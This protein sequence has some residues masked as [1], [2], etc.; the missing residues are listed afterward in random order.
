MPPPN[1]E[2]HPVT[3]SPSPS[4]SM[5][6]E[7]ENAMAPSLDPDQS[8]HQSMHTLHTSS[9]LLPTST[10][11]MLATGG[12][13][14][15]FLS[16]IVPSDH[17][18]NEAAGD[19]ANVNSRPSSTFVG[20]GPQLYQPDSVFTNVENGVDKKGWALGPTDPTIELTSLLADL[21]QYDTK[22]SK[23]S[24]S[25]LQDYPIGDALSLSQR[26]HTI[27][28]NY[29]Y[30]TAAL[31]DVHCQHNTP[32]LLL[33]LSCYAKIAHTYLSIFGYL[34]KG[35]AQLQE[36][37]PADQSNESGH[38][39]SSSHM[40]ISDE[41]IGL[42]LGQVQPKGVHN[43]WDLAIRAKEA[44]SI[45]LGSLSG[46]EKE[47]GL[48]TDLRIV[49]AGPPSGWETGE[50][51]AATAKR[52]LWLHKCFMKEQSGELRSKINEVSDLLS[53]LLKV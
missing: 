6:W 52:S 9:G 34:V 33:T 51:D 23:L 37:T 45:M 24:G 27:I 35:L 47:L 19:E 4:L 43:V 53:K 3:N 21:S 31:T 7:L 41:Y 2:D 10:S 48:P 49:D 8:F 42:R 16:Q 32:I 14:L 26:F 11:S 1:S 50:S 15:G 30:H 39:S 46:V 28:Q 25:G 38:D 36:T 17:Q 44:V 13:D 29:G 12:D 5:W 40:H 22:L 20:P 18:V